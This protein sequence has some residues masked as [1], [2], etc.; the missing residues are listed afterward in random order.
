[1]IF[2]RIASLVGVL[3]VLTLAVFFIQRALPSDPVRLLVG[4]NASPE[5]IAATRARLGLDDPFLVQ[6]AHFLTRLLH[7]DAGVSLRTRNPVAADLARL[8]PA[9]LELVAVAAIIAL[10]G[11]LVLGLLSSRGGWLS[12]S[13]RLVTVA[14][15]SSATFL[16]AIL[17]ILVFYRELG[18]FPAG[19]RSDEF[20]SSK[21]TGLLLVDTL[22]GG[23]LHGWLDAL[24]HVVLPA[25]VLAVGSTVAIGRTLR[26][27]LRTVMQAD[28]VRSAHA[29]GFTWWSVTRR[30]ALRNGAN[31][32]LSMAGLQIG[33]LFSGSIVVELVFSW[34]GVG[35]YLGSSI[36]TADFPAI[37]GVVL[38]LGI[39]YVMIN[40][41]V[42]M[43]QLAVD[44]RLR[45]AA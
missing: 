42:D 38:V 28:F 31:P 8:L 10:V 23:D 36:G 25:T 14:G 26:G 19:G 43:L 12:T 33:M 18:W 29:K 16:V 45:G 30:H 15:S 37:T 13:V 11:G 7:G 5:T 27:S 35:G 24:R 32:A 41:V 17:A 4:R 9:T 22:L 40:F 6:Y 20:S 2:T 21:P 3:V 34:P 1:M 44:P 39:A